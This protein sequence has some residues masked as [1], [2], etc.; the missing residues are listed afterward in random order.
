MKR[1]MKR[2]DVEHKHNRSII[3]DGRDDKS[4]VEFYH[5]NFSYTEQAIRFAEILCAIMN[6]ELG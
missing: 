5:H 1:R 4:V 6:V 2:F 3:W